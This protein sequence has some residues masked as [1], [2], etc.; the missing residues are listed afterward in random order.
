M[1]HARAG[2]I[3]HG[4]KN[5][6]RRERACERLEYALLAS[7]ILKFGGSCPPPATADGRQREAEAENEGQFPLYSRRT[8]E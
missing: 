2:F 4:L 3:M 7:G 6:A 1:Q 8:N 5:S